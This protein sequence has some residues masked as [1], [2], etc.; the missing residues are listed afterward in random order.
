MGN[1]LD[2]IK[3]QGN[4]KIRIRS[5]DGFDAHKTGSAVFSLS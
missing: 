3:W 2:E 4:K 1:A 5:E